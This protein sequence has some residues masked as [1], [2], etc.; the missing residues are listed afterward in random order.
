MPAVMKGSSVA[1]LIDSLLAAEKSLEGFPDW[2]AV[3][4]GDEE[5]LVLPV[6]VWARKA[7]TLQSKLMLIRMLRFCASEYF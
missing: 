2:Q 1:A 4:N 7:Q 3:G 5:R 6:F